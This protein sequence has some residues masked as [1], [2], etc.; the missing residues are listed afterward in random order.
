MT[1]IHAIGIDAAFSN[2]GFC[3]VTITLGRDGK[4]TI[5]CSDLHL[6]TTG[7]EDKKVVRKSSDDLRRAQELKRA[8]VA[9][10]EGAQLAFVEV[11]SGSQSAAAARSLGIAVGVLASCPCPIIEVSPMEVK[12][13]VSQRKKVNPTKPEII[14]W[15]VTQWPDAPWIRHKRRGKGFEV[16]DL[17]NDNEHLA[18]ALATVR[19]GV[20]T[21]EFKRT[22]QFIGKDNEAT[23][24]PDLGPASRKR[25]ELRV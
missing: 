21:V 11:P 7:R 13:A 25:P 10:A 24:T 6:E 17:Q 15:A 1:T 2:M 12:F 22:A 4:A 3:R 20:E 8:L 9:F 18:D 5:K 23:R 19:A 16:G 14:K